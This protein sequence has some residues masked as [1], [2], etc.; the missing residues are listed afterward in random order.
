MYLFYNV[1]SFL[2]IYLRAD[3]LSFPYQSLGESLNVLLMAPKDSY[4]IWI[5]EYFIIISDV[6]PNILRDLIIIFSS[7]SWIILAREHLHRK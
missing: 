6:L 7:A 5:P 2:F 3:L 4:T 1:L